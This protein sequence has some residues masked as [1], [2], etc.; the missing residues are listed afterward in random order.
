MSNVIRLNA[1]P[2]I[3]VNSPEDLKLALDEIEL[4]CLPGELEA[5]EEYRV[6]ALGSYQVECSLPSLQKRNIS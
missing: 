6:L 2:S 5:I 3:V 1:S 4:P